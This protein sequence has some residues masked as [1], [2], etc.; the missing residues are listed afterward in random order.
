MDQIEEENIKLFTLGIGTEEG[1]RIQTG[2]GYKKDRSGEVVVTKLNATSLKQLA[3]NTGGEYFEI[4]N[5]ENGV[6][7]LINQ[8]SQIEG[9]LKDT[10]TIDVSSNRYY[11]FLGAALLF[12]LIDSAFNLRVLQL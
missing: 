9:E 3:A 1:G 11:Y 7:R 6:P 2:R 8:I 10:R 4:N 12:L 5:S